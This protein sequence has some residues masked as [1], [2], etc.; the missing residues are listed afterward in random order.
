MLLSFL[1]FERPAHFVF[2]LFY[3]GYLDERLGFFKQSLAME[4]FY[5]AASAR[6]SFSSW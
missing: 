2:K 6:R 5:I 1:L 3:G 4:Y